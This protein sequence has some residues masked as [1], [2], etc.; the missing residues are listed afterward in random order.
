MES[1]VEVEVND[2]GMLEHVSRNRRWA[3]EK[4]DGKVAT[5]EQS[6]QHPLPE[7]IMAE[8]EQH[9]GDAQAKVTVGAELGH[10]K[11]YG[12]K[13][14]AFV[15]VSVTC[16]SSQ[17]SISAVHSILHTMVRQL[18]NDDLEKMKEDRDAHIGSAPGKVSS[19]PKVQAKTPGKVTARPGVQRPSFRR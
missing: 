2:V 3:V 6:Q 8:L 10:N 7:D 18:V 1:N 13:A 11:E 16:N 19:P 12:C 5:R 4:D 9:I 15:S 17:D 14:Q